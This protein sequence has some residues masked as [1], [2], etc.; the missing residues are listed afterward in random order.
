MKQTRR[1]ALC[2]IH[3]KF[4]SISIG[5]HSVASQTTWFFLRIFT[6]AQRILVHFLWYISQHDQYFCSSQILCK[7]TI[8]NAIYFQ[9]QL[10]LVQVAVPPWTLTY[11]TLKIKLI[12]FTLL[13][14]VASKNVII[15]LYWPIDIHVAFNL[16][17]SAKSLISTQII[18]SKHRSTYCLF[19]EL[20][21]I[22]RSFQHA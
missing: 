11:T 5:L 12:A 13:E 3:P 19:L 2:H 10:I 4:S 18:V 15:M 14:N 6:T 8:I 9:S 20:Y 1:R 7:W 21:S 16:I 17:I 22:Q